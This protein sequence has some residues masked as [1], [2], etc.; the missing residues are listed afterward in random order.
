MQ[1]PKTLRLAGWEPGSYTGGPANWRFLRWGRPLALTFLGLT[2]RADVAEALILL[3]NPA[4]R[5][6]TPFEM[7][8]EGCP[9][10]RRISHAAHSHAGTNESLPHHGSAL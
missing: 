8:E 3:G 7:T 2:K 4:K 6:F 1:L 5:D 10:P 9:Y